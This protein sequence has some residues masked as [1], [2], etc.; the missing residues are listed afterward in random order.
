MKDKK[1]WCSQMISTKTRE[2]LL[3]MAQRNRRSVPSEL[4]IIVEE[5]YNMTFERTKK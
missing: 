3:A 4:E 2:M 1:K 5:Y